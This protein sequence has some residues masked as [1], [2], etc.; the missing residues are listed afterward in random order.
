MYREVIVS[1]DGSGEYYEIAPV[2]LPQLI[3]LPHPPTC[4]ENNDGKEVVGQVIAIMQE[5]SACQ[6]TGDAN[7]LSRKVLERTSSLSVSG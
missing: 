1:F 6:I 5:R 3:R 4:I 7:S 2:L